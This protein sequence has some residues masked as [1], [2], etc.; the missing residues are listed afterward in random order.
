[1]TQ[2][3][4]LFISV[5]M[6]IFLFSSTTYANA[7]QNY[8]SAISN[9]ETSLD[10]L[11]SAIE[12]PP[13][14]NPDF[15]F[16]IAIPSAM[17]ATLE[18]ITMAFAAGYITYQLQQELNLEF[19]AIDTDA[20]SLRALYNQLKSI[21]TRV[22]KSASNIDKLKGQGYSQ[23]EITQIQDDISAQNLKCSRRENN[24]SPD[25]FCPDFKEYFGRE[26]YKIVKKA[27]KVTAW[28]V[29]KAG[30]FACCLEWDRDHCGFEIYNKRGKHQGEVGCLIDEFNPCE[31]NPSRGSHA[32]PDH[33]TH[34]PR[35]QACGK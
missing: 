34:P 28:I 13:D 32:L 20:L 2:K 15:V 21:F 35:S 26:G 6:M 7:E 23:Q 16:V 18:L 10:E 29:E 11:D 17:T 9:M 14:D 33:A 22:E 5:V 31:H 30:R 19:N 8:I 12:N 1:M 27:G 3:L 4:R 24:N 25:N